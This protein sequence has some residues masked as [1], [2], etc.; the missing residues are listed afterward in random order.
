MTLLEWIA[1]IT[2]FK[3]GYAA[4]KY[5]TINRMK[6]FIKKLEKERKCSNST[7]K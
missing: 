5:Q 4:G 6:Q 2:P 1:G 3:M 7:P